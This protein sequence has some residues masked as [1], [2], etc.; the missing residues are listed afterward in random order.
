MQLLFRRKSSDKDT[1]TN[2]FSL[3]LLAVAI[4]Q[5]WLAIQNPKTVT[6]RLIKFTIMVPKAPLDFPKQE[7]KNL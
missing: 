4:Y 1:F 6:T 2:V 3:L 7:G 5:W